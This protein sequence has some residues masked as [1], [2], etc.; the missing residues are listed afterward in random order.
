MIF[1][2]KLTKLEYLIFAVMIFLVEII[3]LLTRTGFFD[4]DD[5]ILNLIGFLIGVSIMKLKLVNKVINGLFI[6]STIKV[7]EYEKNNKF[8]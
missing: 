1:I 7:E 6:L 4:I 8:F 3:Q 2:P 5:I